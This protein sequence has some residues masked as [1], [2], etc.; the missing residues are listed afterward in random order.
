MLS[1]S[2][3]QGTKPPRQ[4]PREQGIRS[5]LMDAEALILGFGS[6]EFLSAQAARREARK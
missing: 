2:R 1:K 6:A 3:E 4:G 5:F